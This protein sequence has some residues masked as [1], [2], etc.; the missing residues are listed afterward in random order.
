[1]K[2]INL[3]KWP[4]LTLLC[5]ALTTVVFIGCKKESINPELTSNA[6]PVAGGSNCTGYNVS[7]VRTNDAFTTTFTWTI[8]NPNP[9]NGSGTTIQSLSHWTFIPGCPTKDGLE[10]NW[11]DILSAEF[12]TGSGWDTITPT[13]ELVRDPSQSCTSAN[14]FKFDQGTTGSAPTMYRL[15]LSGNYSIDSNMV[16]YFKSGSRTGC[17]TKTVPGIGCKIVEVCSLSQGFYFAKP[18]PTWPSNVTIGGFTYTEAEGRAIWNCSNAGGI[19][20][21][22]KAFTQVAALKLS[23]AYPTGNAQIDADVVSIE[24]YLSGLNQKLVA[25]TFLP[26]GTTAGAL[27]AQ[28]AG[29]IG[30]WINN[31]HCP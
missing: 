26:T 15:V 23:N 9:G 3:T 22:K 7:L 18:G 17:C 21:S 27:A 24:A 16:A 10:Q 11:D 19:R 1:M 12:N 5:A 2:Q 14:V 4:L 20:D 25:C 30:D 6:K 8:I 28:A 31:N 29:R 13:P